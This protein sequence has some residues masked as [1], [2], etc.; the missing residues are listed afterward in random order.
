MWLK[1]L[2]GFQES[3]EAIYQN[4][5]VKD[6]VLK[7]KVNGKSYHYGR[8]ETPTLKELRDRV[9]KSKSKSKKGKL[10][11]QAIQA[12]ARALHVDPNNKNALFQVASQFNLLEMVR[13]SV[14]P[15]EGV[16]IY[17]YDNTQGP[18]CAICAGAGTIYRNYFVELDGQFGQSATKQI[19]CLAKVGEASL[20]PIRP[21]W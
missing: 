6:G 18:I 15:E 14:T 13:P 8:L 7:S 9:A 21:R 5:S 3:K 20:V 1:P 4:L 10:K 2:L 17:S 11:L 12:D 19:D 16:N